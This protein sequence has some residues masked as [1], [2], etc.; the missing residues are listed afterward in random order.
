MSSPQAVNPSRATGAVESHEAW[1]RAFV[2]AHQ[3]WCGAFM[4]ELR[5]A[6]V[7]GP[8]IG[9]HLAEVETHCIGSGP[10]S[11]ALVAG[12]LPVTFL[13]LAAVSWLVA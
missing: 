6:E 2:R 9:D 8:Q 13:I 10:W 3:K 11:N 4:T 7:P 12:M 5:L 1:K